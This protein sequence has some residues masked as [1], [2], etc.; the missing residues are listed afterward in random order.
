MKM[1][2]IRMVWNED[3]RKWEDI[4]GLDLELGRVLVSGVVN[5][6]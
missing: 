5:N 6:T 2:E 3:G 4:L 1:R